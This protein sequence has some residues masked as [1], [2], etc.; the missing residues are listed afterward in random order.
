MGG[1]PDN[2]TCVLADV[3]EIGDG[4]QPLAEA[5][6]V[7]AAGMTRLPPGPHETAPGRADSATAP[8][9]VISGDDFDEPVART[10]RRAGKRRRVWPVL[11]SV[12]SVAVVAAGV[13]GYFGWQWTQDQFFV[14]ASADEVVVFQGIQ[15]EVG[16][17]Q[18]FSVIQRTGKSVS[19][20]STARPGADQGRHRGHHLGRGHHQDQRAQVFAKDT[21]EQKA[22]PA[23]SSTPSA[24]PT[25][26][27]P[28]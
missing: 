14:G 21:T 18:F 17:I 1:G 13:G 9:P 6:V 10:S 8:Q 2:I 12:L 28:Q 15:Q 26:T 19:E 22:A 4:Q 23:A 27:K 16:P 7:G 3:L 11:V 20:L 5:A 24:T 25:K